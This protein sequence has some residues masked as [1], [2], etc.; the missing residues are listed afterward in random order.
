MQTVVPTC[1]QD[2]HERNIHINSPLST[3]DQLFCTYNVLQPLTNELN[4]ITDEVSFPTK[5]CV[6]CIVCPSKV[7]LAHECIT[8]EFEPTTK[9]VQRDDV[10]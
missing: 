9:K 7:F 4:S 2:K 3:Y 10:K 6:F 1:K 5:H 8:Q